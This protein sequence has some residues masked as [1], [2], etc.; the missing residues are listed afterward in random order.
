MRKDLHLVLALL[1]QCNAHA[2]RE[3]GLTVGQLDMSILNPS[4]CSQPGANG[5][6]EGRREH[7]ECLDGVQKKL[8]PIAMK[9][10]PAL[11]WKC[12]HSG[13][14]T[15]VVSATESAET[16]AAGSSTGRSQLQVNHHTQVVPACPPVQASSDRTLTP[17]FALEQLP[18]LCSNVRANAQHE[19]PKI[20]IIEAI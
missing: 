8:F 17:R 15:L 2:Q 16:Q 13:S 1:E 19:S 11:D 3:V 5:E 12:M 6:A 9:H 20:A 14:Y 10:T 7:E 18:I 4:S